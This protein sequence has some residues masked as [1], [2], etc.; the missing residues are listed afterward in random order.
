MLM[1]KWGMDADSM[2]FALSEQKYTM[3]TGI[4]HNVEK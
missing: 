2:V 1:S 3:G 4:S